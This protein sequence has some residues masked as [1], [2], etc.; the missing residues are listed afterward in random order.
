M[1][2]TAIVTPELERLLLSTIPTGLLINGQWRDASGGGTFAVEDPATGRTLLE[3][4]DATSA[5]AMAALDAADAVP[6]L[7]GADSPAGT[8]RDPAPRRPGDRTG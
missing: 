1:P 2:E 8:G 6:V 5:D 7:L 3:I 4:A